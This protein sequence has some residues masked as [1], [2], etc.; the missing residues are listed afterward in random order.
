MFDTKK[1][2][3]IQVM[4]VDGQMVSYDNRRLLAAQNANLGSLEVQILDANGPHPA[5][6]KGKTWKQQF[7]KR[8]NDVR[9]KLAGGVVPDKGLK[10]KP[11]LPPCT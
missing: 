8:F 11:T 6:T 1:Y 5:S 2:T 9:N 4:I 10:Q 7:K 3:P